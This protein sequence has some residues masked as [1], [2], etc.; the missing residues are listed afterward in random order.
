MAKKRDQG[1]N[2]VIGPSGSRI[3]GQGPIG[4]SEADVVKRSQRRSTPSDA[5]PSFKGVVLPKTLPSSNVSGFVVGLASRH[6]VQTTRTRLD[7]FAEAVTRLA[8]DEVKLDEVGQT[9]VALRER[10]LVTGDEMN[11]LML[12]HLRERK[13]VRSVR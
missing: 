3:S 4:G 5:Q 10:E 12:N 2:L 8:G 11:R 1:L 7:V 6:G 13:R 9:L